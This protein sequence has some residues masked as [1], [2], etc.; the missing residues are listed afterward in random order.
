MR[1]QKDVKE[2]NQKTILQ[3]LA[4]PKN[5]TELLNSVQSIIRS[6]SALSNH[7]K[8]LK[9]EELIE[10]KVMDDKIV[11]TLTEKGRS[12]IKKTDLY[13]GHARNYFDE[14]I[15]KFIEASDEEFLKE[16]ANKIGALILYSMIKELETGGGWAEVTLPVVKD[17]LW[18]DHHIF[19]QAKV[20][21][22]GPKAGDMKEI[23]KPFDEIRNNPVKFKTQIESM[24]NSLVKLFP[25]EISHIEKL[26]QI[27]Q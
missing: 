13:S 25:S 24:K 18:I 27:Q 23:T 9:K 4:S 19:A 11:Y 2:T 14:E 1:Y 15:R 10:R 6:R 20:G 12:E 26:W 5:F 16:Y 21:A 8:E 22:Y 17:R 7:L 3:Q